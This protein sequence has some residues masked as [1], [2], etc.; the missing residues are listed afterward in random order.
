MKGFF[1]FMAIFVISIASF[2]GYYQE[3]GQ[4]Y[5]EKVVADEGGPY[6]N[7]TFDKLKA[8]EKEAFKLK[9]ESD[10]SARLLIAKFAD[11]TNK[12][13]YFLKIAEETKLMYLDSPLVQKDGL[14]DLIFK[15]A[16]Y[17]QD[18]NRYQEAYAL[19][20]QFMEIYPNHPD[21]PSARRDSEHLRFK[22][23]LG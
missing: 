15:L 22:Y 3:I 4:W 17:Y 23:T 8:D 13:A 11:W 1:I 20:K 10:L 9:F 12:E 2:M 18:L 16:E 21:V 19:F 6:P 5:M 14:G 7:P